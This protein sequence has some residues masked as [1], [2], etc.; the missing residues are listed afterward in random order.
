MY[1]ASPESQC[2]NLRR[3]RKLNVCFQFVYT[4][5]K[6]V[7]VSWASPG[8]RA[9]RTTTILGKPLKFTVKISYAEKIFEIDREKPGF[10]R[11]RPPSK[12]WRRH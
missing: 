7:V 12:S 8:G 1:V 5:L 9:T 6:T 11:K 2:N 4:A 3:E 10:L